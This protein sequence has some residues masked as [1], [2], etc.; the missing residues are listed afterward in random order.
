M[1]N[2]KPIHDIV[3]YT[4]AKIK[5]LRIAKGLTQEDF[6]TALG[7]SRTSIL[8]MEKGRHGI[9]L[10]NL[11]T[12]CILLECTPNDLLPPIKEHYEIVIKE[13]TIMVPKVVKTRV[14]KKIA[15]K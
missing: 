10:E 12:V 14:L 5:D 1:S 15:K 11:Y 6:A 7:L 8:N 13:K 2:H 9:T 4:A 3:A